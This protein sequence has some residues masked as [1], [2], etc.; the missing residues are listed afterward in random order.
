M[1]ALTN[2]EAQIAVHLANSASVEE[3]AFER[4]SSEQTVRT[5]IKAIMSKM[6]TRRQSEVSAI[7]TRLR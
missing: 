7:V 4:G 6:N 2:A 1:Y 5:Q 3:I